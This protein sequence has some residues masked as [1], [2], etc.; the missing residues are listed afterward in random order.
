MNESLAFQD[1]IKKEERQKKE[2]KESPAP[3]D[4]GSNDGMTDVT[5]KT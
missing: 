2:K 4:E 3:K 1:K 5:V